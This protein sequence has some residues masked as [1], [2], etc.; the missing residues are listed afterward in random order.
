MEQKILIVDDEAHIRMLIEQTLE[1]LEDE[2]VD[3]F[4]A[5]NGEQALQI[6]QEEEPQLVF[7]DVMMPKMNGME[8]CSRVKK[9]LGLEK[10]FIILL[11][12]K[13]QEL[14]K[15]KGQEVGAD[16]YM[17]KPF[18]PEIVLNKAKEVLALL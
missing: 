8:V 4:T 13:G 15:Q 17:T 16:L 2:G 10:V 14:D 1:E 18:D 6:I 9:E 3:F 12:A 5:E 7:L 11:T